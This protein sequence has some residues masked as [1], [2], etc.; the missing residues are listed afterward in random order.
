MEPPRADSFFATPRQRRLVWLA[1]LFC[2]TAALVTPIHDESSWVVVSFNLDLKFIAAKA[3]HVLGYG[4]LAA[5]TGW[6]RSPLRIRWVLMF[7]VMSHPPLTELIQQFVPGRTGSLHDVGLDL[8]GIVLG[9][10]LT[11]KWWSEV[12]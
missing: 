9:L 10:M 1:Y 12:K 11:R 7:I 8:V 5:L 4:L 6:L 2:W 3:L